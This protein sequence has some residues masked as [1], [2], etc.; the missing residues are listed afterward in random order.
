MKA[1]N[2]D[3]IKGVEGKGDIAKIVTRMKAKF[4]KNLNYRRLMTHGYNIS[5]IQSRKQVEI[6]GKRKHKTKAAFQVISSDQ[7]GK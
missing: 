4:M 3:Y 2:I 5:K 1:L 6:E 7:G